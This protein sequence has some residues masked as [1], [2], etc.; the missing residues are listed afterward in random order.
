M[1][2][3]DDDDTPFTVSNCVCFSRM[4]Y[5]GSPLLSIFQP[6]GNQLGDSIDAMTVNSNF[7]AVAVAERLASMDEQ[8]AQISYY[9][10]CSCSCAE[11]Q[12]P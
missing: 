5:T 4:N 2:D 9:F 12:C 7:V 1:N 6:G 10:P 3:D 11:D 8:P